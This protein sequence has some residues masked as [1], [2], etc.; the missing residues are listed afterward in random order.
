[1]RSRCIQKVLR[2]KFMAHR[3]RCRQATN[4]VPT[5][6]NDATSCAHKNAMW[7]MNGTKQWKAFA[8][9]RRNIQ[10][11]LSPSSSIPKSRELIVNEHEEDRAKRGNWRW[12]T[13][14]EFRNLFSLEEGGCAWGMA[15][16]CEEGC[17][18]HIIC[19]EKKRKN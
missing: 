9:S 19:L 12:L 18:Y 3:R 11:R 14:C 8:F 2:G 5:S 4:L 13:D 7:R 1:M 17:S 6:A 10:P 15:S 16:D